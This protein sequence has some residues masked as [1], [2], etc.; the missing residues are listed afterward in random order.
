MALPVEDANDNTSDADAV[1]NPQVSFN[2]IMQHQTQTRFSVAGRA[3]QKQAAP[4]RNGEFGNLNGMFRKNKVF[5]AVSDFL[6]RHHISLGDLPLEH[7]SV[8]FQ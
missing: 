2:G 1:R 6:L 5:D 8:R 7:G 3:E 4:G